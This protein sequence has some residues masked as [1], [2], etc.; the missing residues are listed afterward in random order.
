MHSPNS[1]P[2]FALSRYASERPLNYRMLVYIGICSCVFILLSTALQMRFDYLREMKAI[3]QRMQL[4]NES[5]IATLSK[6]L[7]DLDQAQQKLQLTGIRALPYVAYINLQDF[8]L[9]KNTRIP[10]NAIA[11]EDHQLEVFDLV[12]ASNQQRSKM[13][14]RLEVAI[15]LSSIHTELWQNGLRILLNQSLLMLLIMAAITVILQRSITRHLEH[16]AKYSRE[17]GAG[18]LNNALQLQRKKP[19]Q[20]DELDQLQSALNEMRLSIR[21]D[22]EQRDQAASALRYNRDQLQKMVEV[23]TQSLQQ[24]KEVAEYANSAKSQFLATMSHEIRTPMNGMLGMIQLLGNSDLSTAQD[25]QVNVLQDSTHA[26]LGTFDHILQYA[27]LEQGVYQDSDVLFSLNTLLMNLVDLLQLGAEQKGLVLKLVCP[28][29]SVLY[30]DKAASLRQIITNL[31]ANAIKFSDRGCITITVNIDDTTTAQHAVCISINDQGIGIDPSMQQHIFGRFTQADETI[32]RRFGGTGLGLS[33]S[34]QLTESMGGT[35]NLVS[36]LGE[37]STFN[38][39]VYLAPAAKEQKLLAPVAPVLPELK[40]LLVEDE[41]INRQVMQSL[42]ANHHLAIAQ[43]ADSAVALAAAQRYDLILMDMH[44]GGVSGLDASRII[45]SDRYSPN[46]HTPII[47]VTASVRPADVERYL[48]QGIQKVVAKPV[49]QQELF[50]SIQEVIANSNAEPT[51]S[52]QSALALD[53]GPSTPPLLDQLLME[54]NRQI[55][56]TTKLNELMGTFY[57]NGQ[58][59]WQDLLQSVTQL[60]FNESEQLAHKLAGSCDTLGFCRA[61]QHLRR[62]EQRAQ[63]KDATLSADLTASIEQSFALAKQYNKS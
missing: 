30:F 48:A 17:I 26:L 60:D 32:T 25:R 62:L 3:E 23:R 49:F 21:A 29:E 5:Y 45:R 41:Q 8:T 33:I 24:A 1:H 18:K 61:S 9:H 11:D 55:L 12:N 10:S 35:L 42:L 2:F 52:F 56:G 14:G 6:S 13:L 36:S 20:G 39:T 22:I 40:I 37:G 58:Q 38:A 44:L 57:V 16:M 47:A 51:T 63:Q 27:Q 59:I 46:Y 4:I 15:D 31:L 28:N 53:S 54:T 19:H 43:D 7:W 50:E 34:K